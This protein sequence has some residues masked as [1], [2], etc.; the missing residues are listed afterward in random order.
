MR[1]IVGIV[2][3][4]ALC[5]GGIRGLNSFLVSRELANDPTISQHAAESAAWK[6]VKQYHA[7]VYVAAGLLTLV[8]CSLPTVLDKQ[9]SYN[10]QG[11]WREKAERRAAER[12]QRY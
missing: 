11:G 10:E 7:Y 8:F 9:G 5:Y 2:L 3:F 6:V 4:V 1:C 12:L